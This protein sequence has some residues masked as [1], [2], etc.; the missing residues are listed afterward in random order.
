ML[1]KIVFWRSVQNQSQGTNNSSAETNKTQ[2]CV[3]VVVFLRHTLR[4]CAHTAVRFR[5]A[6]HLG[7]TVY[8][9]PVLTVR[10]H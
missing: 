3:V 6:V 4:T 8:F 1:T 2:M 7:F 10:Q 9:G 5:F